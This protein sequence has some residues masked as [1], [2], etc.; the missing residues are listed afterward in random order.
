MDEKIDKFATEENATAIIRKKPLE[1]FRTDAD[2]TGRDV[3]QMSDFFDGYI[4]Q[5]SLAL[6]EQSGLETISE[7]PVSDMNLLG[8]VVQTIDTIRKGSTMLMPDFDS[9]PADILSKLKKGIYSLGESKQ[10]EGNSRPVIVDENGVRVKDITLKRVSSDSGNLETARSIGD[11]LQM[12]QIYAKLASIEEFQTYQLERNRDNTMV[13][14]FLDARTLVLQ[15]GNASDPQEQRQLLLKANE[16]ITSAI[17]SVYTDMDT[18]ARRLAKKTGFFS[19]GFTRSMDDYMRFLTSDLQ[20][21]TK[22]VGV[23]MQVLEYIGDPKSAQNVLREYQQT[24]YDFLTKPLTKKGLSAAGI[25]HNYFPYSEENK[26]CWYTFAKETTP[27]LES[28]LK[29]AQLEL[30]KTDTSDI[31]IVSLEDV[32]DG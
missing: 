13:V 9:V 6:R 21:A 1:I 18:V 8:E 32:N 26:N 12:K 28:G 11:Q 3:S 14:P 31:Y 25:M 30:G 27:L 19:L 20:F 7:I 10:V 2:I 17:H 16:K 24:V 23:S 29:Q 5:M 22:Y 4:Q 15:A